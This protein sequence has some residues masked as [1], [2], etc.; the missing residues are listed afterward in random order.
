MARQ[1]R[2]L[3]TRQTVL[4]A[5]AEVFDERGYAAATMSEILDRAGVTK[6]ALYFHFRS[7]EELALAVIEGQGAWIAGWE[8]ASDSSVQNLIDL[9]YAFARALQSDPLVRGS[10]RLTIEHGSFTQPQIAAY[11][12]WMDLVRAL[13]EQARDAG[14]LHPGID[15][16]A[17]SG[18]ITGAVTGIQLSSQVLADR[19]DLI[20][21]MADLWTLLLPGLVQPHALAR[22]SVAERTP[23]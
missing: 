23:S 12:G 18:V 15:L 20:Q 3:A 21:R 8:P 5:A 10:I 1:A 6:G 22:L 17:A 4:L 16:V 11:Q 2:A 9:G 7:K 14:D 19:Q 13:L